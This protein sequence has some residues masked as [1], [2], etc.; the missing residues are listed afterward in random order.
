MIAMQVST[1]LF[2]QQA[3]ARM[4][5]LMDR[6]NTLNTQLS[7]GK[8]VQSPS[9]DA[10][11]AQQ[12]AEFDRK[13]ADAATYKGNITLASS[14]LSQADSVM[15]QMS[16]QLKRAIE[17][18]SS[19]ATGTQTADTRKSLGIEMSS[20]VDSLVGLAN[21]R[22]ARGQP[23][24]GTPDGT[25][26]VTANANGTYTFATVNVS[27]V[28]IGDGQTV[29][30][31]ES[32]SR[33]FDLGGGNDTLTKL[34]AIADALSAGNAPPAGAMD[35]VT[36]ANSQ[37]DYVQSSVGARGARVDLQDSLLTTANTDRQELRD[38]LENIDWPS[39]MA[40]LQQTMTVLSATQASFSKLANLSIFDYMR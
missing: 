14:L 17:I 6:A 3:G 30:A 15:T 33:I 4:T 31:T 37:L 39:T 11:L 1:S 24:F 21:Q 7:T 32:A 25:P 20:L 26:A 23:L 2:Y 16:A 5:A 8:K 10:V 9:D 38:K 29:Q 35:D 36:A 34:K 22:N 27:E 13:D 40:E 18:T 19:A 28:P 12:V